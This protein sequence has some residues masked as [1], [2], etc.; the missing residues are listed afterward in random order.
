MTAPV[1]TPGLGTKLQAEISTVYTDIAAILNISIDGNEWNI[2]DIS[3][4]TTTAKR[5]RAVN[6][7]GGS[8]T[9][10]IQL[11]PAHTTHAFLETTYA[12]G[13]AINWKVILADTGACVYSFS[14]IIKSR[15]LAGMS[16][17]EDVTSKLEIKVDGDI[18]V[19]P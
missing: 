15:N 3:N 10:E 4:I 11:D 14:G 2:K 13:V 19:T 18:V 7:E 6:K 12:A 16:E 8:I 9:F 17:Q 1:I 5:Y